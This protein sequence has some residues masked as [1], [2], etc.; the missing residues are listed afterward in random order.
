[1]SSRRPDR[2]IAILSHR[3]ITLLIRNPAAIM[4]SILFPL[5]FFLLFNMIGRKMMT[6]QGFD[7]AQVLPP[8]V[9][10]QAMFF[11]SMSSA[12]YI[13]TD[14]LSGMTGRLRSLPI[15]R[16]APQVARTAGDLSRAA[17]SIVILMIVGVITGMRFQ[18]GLLT[19]PAFF[20]V[21]L[22]FAA[23]TSM[24]MGLIGTRTATAEAAVSIAAIPY[25]PL[26]ML[27]N[28]FAPAAQF[29]SWL[30]GFI[31]HQPV[32]RTLDLLR[33][34]LSDNTPLTTPL[35]WWLGW[36]VGLMAIFVFLAGRA[37][38]SSI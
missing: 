22:G 27:S 18:S 28:G 13:A 30:Q 8:T 33:A 3:A 10:I 2:D 23:V 36:M 16:I 19:I 29:P 12:M 1:M 38:R 17:L 31:T 7:Y 34:L 26:L 9:I 15:S 32:S 35:W 21:S 11:A 37:M 24:G 5:I 25:L 14:R 20:L 4:G 6:A